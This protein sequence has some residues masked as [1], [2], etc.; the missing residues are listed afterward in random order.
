MPAAGWRRGRSTASCGARPSSSIPAST[1]TSALRR[2]VPP[3]AP[4]A[5]ARPSPSSA[6][7]GDIMLPIRCA[8]PERLADQ[9]G[10]AEHAVQVQVEPGQPVARAEP[11]AGREHAGVA[12]RR[13]RVTRLVVSPVAV[14]PVERA[15]R[16][17]RRASPGDRPRSRGR[18]SRQSASGAS[19]ARVSTRVPAYGTSTGSDQT[20][21]YAG[22]VVARDEAAAL[23]HQLEQRLAERP[24]VRAS[25]PLVGEQLERAHEARLA[26]AGRLACSSVP[27]GE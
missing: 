12:L 15:R 1:C 23:V 27:P 18:R 17:R 11:E 13:R 2:R 22:E 26:R 8:G 21:S 6:S 25:R 7:V 14:R 10:L 4:A 5:K 16:A 9:V 19:P 3:A 20:A 24:L